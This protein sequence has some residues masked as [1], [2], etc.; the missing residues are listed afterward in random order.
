MARKLLIVSILLLLT[1]VSFAQKKKKDREK[2]GQTE[3]NSTYNEI[4]ATLP[5]LNFY[6]RDGISLTEKDLNANAPLIIM[7]FNP[8]CEHCE[9]QAK[10]FQQHL[11]W[12]KDTE[13]LLMAAEHMGPY[14]GY[15]VSN[16]GSDKYPSLQIGLDSSNFIKNTFRYE[17]LPQINVYDKQ[18]K[19]VKVFTGITPI[20][21][22]KPY[23]Q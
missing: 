23:I 5:P 3:A 8:T 22:L 2:K 17:S 15:F 12:F 16:T 20:D 6:R 18:R 19:L 1:S 14:L 13:L 11:S 10:I 4:G 9:Q 7:L 21:S